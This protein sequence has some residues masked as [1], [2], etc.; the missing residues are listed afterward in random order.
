MI[1]LI[2]LIIKSIAIFFLLGGWIA[3]I[4]FLALGTIIVIS[5]KTKKARVK[6]RRERLKRRKAR[7]RVKARKKKFEQEK[8]SRQSDYK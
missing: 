8:R 2:K 4:G 3:F 1:A 5:Q 7:Q 6:A